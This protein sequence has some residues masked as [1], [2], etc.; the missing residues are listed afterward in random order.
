M[1][2]RVIHRTHE[3]RQYQLVKLA[4]ARAVLA[5]KPA[6]GLTSEQRASIELKHKLDVMQKI[7]QK[8]AAA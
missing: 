6:A 1:V 8:R 7:Q 4:Q 3:Q 5:A 2:G